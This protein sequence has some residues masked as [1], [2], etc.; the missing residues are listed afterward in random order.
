MRRDCSEGLSR[1]DAEARRKEAV[2]SA[3]PRLRV[4][5]IKNHRSSSTDLPA[6]H[7]TMR[8]SRVLTQTSFASPL[9]ALVKW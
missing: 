5:K 8:P 1:G 9:F 2:F 6:V 7:F 3:S 4:K